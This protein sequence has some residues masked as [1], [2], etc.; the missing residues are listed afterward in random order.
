VFNGFEIY[1][2]GNLDVN[3]KT[4][5]GQIPDFYNFPLTYSIGTSFENFRSFRGGMDAV[6]FI[7]GELNQ[8]EK[9]A[10]YNSKGCDF[11]Y[12]PPKRIIPA[13]VNTPSYYQSSK[14]LDVSSKVN[15][16]TILYAGNSIFLKN[17]F[18]AKNTTFSAEIQNCPN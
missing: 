5:Q 11:Q 16:K 3:T 8:Y 17:G 7:H 14:S 6:K 2:N 15:A 18:E 9:N 1:I 13:V 10:V 4:V 12:C